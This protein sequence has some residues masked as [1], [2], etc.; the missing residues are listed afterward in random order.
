MEP[1]PAGT[2]AGLGHPI[3]SG[4]GA[5]RHPDAGGLRA[6]CP[7]VRGSLRARGRRDRRPAGR[8]CGCGAVSGLF[9][10]AALFG[11]CDFDLYHRGGL[12][13]AEAAGGAAVSPSGRGGTVSGGERHLCAPV[14]VPP[15]EPGALPGGDGPGGH[16]RLVLSA[17]A[18][19]GRGAA[20]AGQPAVSGRLH[21]AGAGGCGTGRRLRGAFVA[22]PAAGLHR[23]SAGGHDRGSRRWRAF[24][25]GAAAAEGGS[26]RRWHSGGRRPWPLCRRASPRPCCRRP[27]WEPSCF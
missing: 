16:L 5:D 26:G 4:G 8:R 9:R 23:L 18:A 19:D 7:G 1:A 25:P 17:P 20:G 24:W 21:S 14:P 22:V 12:S 10:C 13:G 11:R 6:L 3:F 2:A 15:A 27:R